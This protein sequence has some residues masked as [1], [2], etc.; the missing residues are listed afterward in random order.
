MLPTKEEA[1]FLSY[2][3]VILA[4]GIAPFFEEIYFRGH[5]FPALRNKMNLPMA[6]IINGLMF[7]AWHTTRGPYG[8]IIAFSSTSAAGAVSCYLY[9]RTETL[10]STIFVH[11]IFNLGMMLI[12]VY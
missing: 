5:L 2:Y 7:A 1:T 10:Y 3:E 11:A 9:E 8:W 6:M 12:S 4:V